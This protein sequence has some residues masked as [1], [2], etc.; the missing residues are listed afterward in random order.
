MLQKWNKK[1][2]LF[3]H[4]WFNFSW[5]SSRKNWF[6]TINIC[7]NLT[8]FFEQDYLLNLVIVGVYEKRWP[9]CPRISKQKIVQPKI[10]LIF[11]F[12]LWLSK[13]LYIG[14]IL[15]RK[16]YVGPSLISVKIE[17]LYL[18]LSKRAESATSSYYAMGDFLQYIYSV[19]VAIIRRPD[20][21][22]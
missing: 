18:E 22:F 2:C 8:H 3:L 10:W 9:K 21:G 4:F 6:Y 20:R 15:S 16:K 1:D 14:K 13:D 19:F 7:S 17:A 12:K 11:F 5:R